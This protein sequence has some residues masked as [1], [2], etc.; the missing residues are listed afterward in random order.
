M[1]VRFKLI[2]K[3]LFKLL[4][5]FFIHLA[6]QTSVGAVHLAITVAYRNYITYIPIHK[7]LFASPSV[8]IP[9]ISKILYIYI[10][11]Y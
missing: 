2:L 1:S 7:Y 8:L 4:Y 10:I 6:R 5:S 11:M 9:L 3:R